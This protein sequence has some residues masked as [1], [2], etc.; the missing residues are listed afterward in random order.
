MFDRYLDQFRVALYI[1]LLCGLVGCIWYFYEWAYDRGEVHKQAEW[2]ADKAERVQAA[3]EASIANRAKEKLLNDKVRK[4]SDDYQKLQSANASVALELERVQHDF[5]TALNSRCAEN[6]TATG[7]ANGTG[8]LEQELLRHCAAT[9][10]GIS[11][12]ADRLE[13]KVV[14]LQS[15]IKSTQ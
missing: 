1:A 4:V 7:C 9:L 12:Q 8:G 2:D 13:A 3:L 11:K 15:F 14:G 5:E 6:P 10:V